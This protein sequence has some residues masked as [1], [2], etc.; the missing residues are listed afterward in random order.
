MGTV[1]IDQE[2][3]AVTL[4]EGFE[5]IEHKELERLMDISYDCLW[6]VRDTGRHMMITV[7]WKDSS[8]LLTKLVNERGRA[9]QIDKNYARCRNGEAYRSDGIKERAVTGADAPASGFHFAYRVEDVDQ[10][11]EVWVFKRGIR[12]YTLVIYTRSEVAA[13]NAAVLE[14]I[15]ASLTVQ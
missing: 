2:Y 1:R 11:G 15:L 5:V 10:E 4:P 3:L 14:D 8:K 9:K 13:D 7:T 12:C 6:G